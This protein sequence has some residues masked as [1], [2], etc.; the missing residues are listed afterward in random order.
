MTWRLVSRW[1]T[2]VSQT[3]E[4]LLWLHVPI[5]TVS[6]SINCKIRRHQFQYLIM[7]CLKVRRFWFPTQI[8]RCRSRR[9]NIKDT[10]RTTEFINT[11]SWNLTWGCDYFFNLDEGFRPQFVLFPTIGSF[12]CVQV[13][14]FPLIEIHQLQKWLQFWTVCDEAEE[15]SPILL[16][17]GLKLK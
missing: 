3:G 2:W 8:S 17:V 1:H 7:K 13:S 14:Y 6:G 9:T 12:S 10:F 15:T 11:N 4:S 16:N 5:R